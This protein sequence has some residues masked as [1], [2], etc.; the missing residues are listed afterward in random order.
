MKTIKDESNLKRY[1][2]NLEKENESLRKSHSY[3]VGKSL[4]NLRDALRN[5]AAREISD[6]ARELLAA[7]KKLNK[8]PT[9]AFID[10]EEILKKKSKTNKKTPVVNDINVFNKDNVNHYFVPKLK[11]RR[12]V[13]VFTHDQTEMDKEN[14]Y[15]LLTPDNYNDVINKSGI[16]T[17]VFDLK[18]I[19][20]NSV[21]FA[22]GT[23]DAIYLLKGLVS[24][25]KT[26][27]SITTVV[28]ENEDIILFPLILELKNIGFFDRVT[29]KD[30]SHLI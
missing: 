27:K 14:I 1:V 2:F 23:Y 13:G 30:N 28:I 19:R 15:I 16:E 25:L 3:R 12:V 9:H 29:D 10:I 11:Y 24:Q 17:I 22:L 20:N 18:A 21:W 4:I 7:T 6:T 26:Q 8:T 5:K